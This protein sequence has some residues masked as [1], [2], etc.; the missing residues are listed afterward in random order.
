[1]GMISHI[2]WSLQRMGPTHVNDFSGQMWVVPDQGIVH[3]PPL[4]VQQSL[5][6]GAFPHYCLS[7]GG[8]PLIN[9]YVHC[10]VELCVMMAMYGK[11]SATI[12]FS[13]KC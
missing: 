12:A 3:P 8:L 1:M 10:E 4:F 9:G 11:L 2:P 13:R 6:F 5:R 7:M